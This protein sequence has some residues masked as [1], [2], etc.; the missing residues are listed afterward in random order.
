M[1]NLLCIC[2]L[3]FWMQ[4]KGQTTLSFNKIDINPGAGSS[5]PGHMMEFNGKIFLVAFAD[6]F[7]FEPWITDGTMQGTYM[8]KD[9]YTGKGVKT[10]L[11]SMSRSVF[12]AVNSY[13]IDWPVLNGKLFFNATDSV[14]GHNVWS[15]DGTVNGTKMAID[16]LPGNPN[17]GGG[18]ELILFDSVILFTKP[19]DYELWST[20]GTQQGTYMVKDIPGIQSRP[21]HFCKYKGKVYFAARDTALKLNLWETDGTEQGTKLVR[22]F[23]AIEQIHSLNNKLFFVARTLSDGLEWHVYNGNAPQLL[24]DIN[25]GADSG[26]VRNFYQMAAYNGKAYFAAD[27]GNTGAELWVTDGTYAGTQLLKDINPGPASS[28]PCNFTEHDDKLYFQAID[29]T[30]GAELWVTNGTDT[31]TRL[32]KDILP[33]PQGSFP[34]HQISYGEHLYFAAMAASADTQLMRT[35]GTAPGT[36]VVR[37]PT[38]VK[39]NPLERS[40]A[41]IVFDSSLYFGADFDSSGMELWSLREIPDPDYIPVTAADRNVFAVYPNPAEDALYISMYEDFRE[42]EV[43][44]YDVAGKL[45][46]V[47]NIDRA[48]NTLVLMLPPGMSPG[49]Y[50]VSVRINGH[51]SGATFVKQ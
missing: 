16:L 6:S 48:G 5:L 51:T 47:Q 15:T 40:L 1:K 19:H 49:N 39:N 38:A 45:I 28:R 3:L 24:R 10:W 2:A 41:F 44:V 13:S 20:D 35:D 26:A 22:H 12:H 34:S 23:E 37:P 30:N 50:V 21:R 17:W 33:G 43:F 36:V 11:G 9:I 25:P 27:D 31:G 46:P 42:A 7:G 18:A 8:L 14:D 32:V 4:A 29:A